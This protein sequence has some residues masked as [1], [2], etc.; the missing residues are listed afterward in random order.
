MAEDLHPKKD[1]IQYLQ[2]INVS[3]LARPAL[4]M[5]NMFPDH[6][7]QSNFVVKKA[8]LLMRFTAYMKTKK[9]NLGKWCAALV[10]RKTWQCTD[11]LIPQVYP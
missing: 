11:Y 6:V 2:K 5:K 1:N 9:A 10:R 4:P 8:L 3:Y 7:K